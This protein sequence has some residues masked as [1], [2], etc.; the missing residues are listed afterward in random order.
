M[1]DG[2]IIQVDALICATGFDT[3]FRPAFPVIGQEGKD[4]RD[5]WKEEPRAYLSVAASGFPNYFRK[6]TH[7]KVKRLNERLSFAFF[8]RALITLINSISTVTSGPNFPLANGALVPCLEKCIQYAFD[9]AQKIQTQGIKSLSVKQEAVDDFQEHKD[10]I[11]KDLVWSSACRSWCVIF[12]LF[13]CLVFLSSA[14]SNCSLLGYL[15]R[16]WSNSSQVQKR[17][18]RRQGVGSVVWLLYPVS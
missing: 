4:L 11:M 6:Y 15:L 9:A 5:V 7:P 3:S 18:D 12:A 16:K 17:E 8:C 13:H 1:E 2:T 14:V 10:A